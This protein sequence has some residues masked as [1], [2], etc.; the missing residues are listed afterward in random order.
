MKI[1]VMKPKH[2]FIVGNFVLQEFK[3][4][5]GGIIE[6][7]IECGELVEVHTC[8]ESKI[9]KVVEIKYCKDTLP[10]A[11]EGLSC[12]LVFE[13]IHE[14]TF[15]ITPNRINLFDPKTQLEEY[16]AME[17]ENNVAEG[18]FITKYVI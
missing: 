13:N 9:C 5:L 2:F 12:G 18:V 16:C 3:T 7:E 6:Y 8:K 1:L 15:K 11:L 17:K 14:M 10:K 4:V